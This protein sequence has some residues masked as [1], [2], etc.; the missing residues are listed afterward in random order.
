MAQ[1]NL[2]TK[3]EILQLLKTFNE[4]TVAKLSQKLNITEMAVRRHL[5]NL[6]NDGYIT[7]SLIRKSLGRPLSVYTLTEK[8]E[9]TFPKQYKD[10]LLDFVG[11]LEEKGEEELVLQFFENKFKEIYDTTAIDIENSSFTEKVEHVAK[12]QDAQGHMVEYDIINDSNTA[13]VKQSHCTISQ[14]ATHYPSVCECEKK[15]IQKFFPNQEV[16]L[17]CSLSNGDKACAFLIK[18]RQ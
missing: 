18:E 13:E 14:L 5:Q 10:V 15:M 4:Q 7:S 2:N 12:L 1:V 8:G 17:H 16:E 11:F 9:D 6:E 3:D